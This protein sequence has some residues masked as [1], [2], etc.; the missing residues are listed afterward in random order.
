MSSRAHREPAPEPWQQLSAIA[1]EH[2]RLA[3]ECEKEA[4]RL[5]LKSCVKAQLDA[6]LDS[7]I[8][9]K[10]RQ[11]TAARRAIRAAHLTIDEC[12]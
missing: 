6:V 2:R 11:K 12:L 8:Q 10:R 3:G 1:R 9:K 5:W 4:L 7:G